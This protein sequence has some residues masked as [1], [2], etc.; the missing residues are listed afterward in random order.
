MIQRE[1][2][3]DS[4][5][6]A[7]EL[8]EIFRYDV[9][10]FI[11]L[12]KRYVEA[13]IPEGKDRKRD[14]LLGVVREHVNRDLGDDDKLS[15]EA[16]RA[17]LWERFGNDPDV[18]NDLALEY[19]A[20]G[21]DRLA[22]AVEKL[23][24]DDPVTEIPK[25]IGIDR[26]KSFAGLSSAIGASPEETKAAIAKR[27]AKTVYDYLAASMDLRG[28]KIKNISVPTQS[29]VAQYIEIFGYNPFESSCG[30]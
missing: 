15:D 14:E 24:F 2:N 29:E 13:E 10:Q 16:I 1:L 4:D 6:A 11:N 17:L 23:S 21:T 9:G 22:N 8:R 20:Q 30:T 28:F 26:T 18:L 12:T 3:K 27:G 19:L 5:A 7:S 25:E